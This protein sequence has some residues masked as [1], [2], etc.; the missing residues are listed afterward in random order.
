MRKRFFKLIYELMAKDKDIFFLTG[1]LGRG[2][3]DLIYRNYPNRFLDCGAA[4]QGMIGI[5]VGLA[6]SGKKVFCYS[7]TPFLLFRPAEFIRNYISKE[8]IPVCLCASG[9]YADYKTEGFTHFAGDD[10]DF[11]MTFKPNILVHW[12]ET[13]PEMEAIV[14]RFVGKP[15]S[16]YLNLKR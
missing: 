2:G 16:T 8:R 13:E 11:M 10:L 1:N 12:P 5:A 7:I 14:K 6:L 3:V 9:R 4:E 15:D